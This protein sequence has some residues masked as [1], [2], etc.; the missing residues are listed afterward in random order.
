MSGTEGQG[1]SD[2]RMWDMTKVILFGQSHYLKVNDVINPV[3]KLNSSVADH[4]DIG[5]QLKV[6]NW[7]VRA[8]TCVSF[9]MRY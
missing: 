6:L 2:R 8:F 5:T 1:G 9:R 3:K 4:I 7:I